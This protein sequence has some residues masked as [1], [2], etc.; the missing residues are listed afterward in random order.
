MVL[1]IHLYGLRLFSHWRF[2]KDKLSIVLTEFTNIFGDLNI[3]WGITATTK[4]KIYAATNEIGA[5]AL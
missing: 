3:R 4:K 5:V 2:T 1:R